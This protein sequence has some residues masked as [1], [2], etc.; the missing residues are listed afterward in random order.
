MFSCLVFCLAITLAQNGLDRGFRC[1]VL[2]ARKLC[3]LNELSTFNQSFHFFHGDE[4]I[5]DSVLFARPR[6]L[7]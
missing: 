6:T 1:S 3:I 7:N 5:M 2:I 4:M